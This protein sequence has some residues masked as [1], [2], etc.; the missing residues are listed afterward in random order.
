MRTHRA[1]INPDSGSWPVVN[2]H[3][4]SIMSEVL[5]SVL[6]CFNWRLFV[7]NGL[8]ILHHNLQAYQPAARRL[9]EEQVNQSL[10]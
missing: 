7:Q 6:L 5:V 2:G 1:R 8:F 4:K 9:E 10:L 3:V